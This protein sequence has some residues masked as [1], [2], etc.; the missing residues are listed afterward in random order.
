M[1]AWQPWRFRCT[2]FAKPTC[3]R[4][5]SFSSLCEKIKR[6]KWSFN[7]LVEAQRFELWTQWLKVIC[8]TNWAMPPKLCILHQVWAI[9]WHIKNK[10]SRNFYT[11][12]QKTW[13]WT[14]NRFWWIG[15]QKGYYR[16]RV[17]FHPMILIE[18]SHQYNLYECL[19]F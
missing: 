16:Y 9:F 10:K 15:K 18:N 19:G 11:F 14:L 3:C 12:L 17:Q 8:S 13:N 7:F 4:T 6:P 5:L 2:L 1:P